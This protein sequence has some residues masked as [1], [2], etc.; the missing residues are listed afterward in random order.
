[1]HEQLD[2]LVDLAA[3]GVLRL[4]LDVGI[5]LLEVAPDPLH[6]LLLPDGGPPDD[7]EANRLAAG[8]G[9]LGGRL[10]GS[11]GRGRLGGGLGGRGGGGRLG[12]AGRRGRRRSRSRGRSRRGRRARRRGRGAGGEQ[13]ARRAKRGQLEEG[14]PIREL[15]VLHSQSLR[16]P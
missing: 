11:G 3:G 13:G 5:L 10:G 7:G 12:G 14:A 16:F 8:R 1:G 9:R 4:D 6:R 2:L 15:A